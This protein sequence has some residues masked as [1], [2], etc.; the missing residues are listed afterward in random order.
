MKTK[1]KIP[2]PDFDTVKT[3]REIKEQISKE[4]TGM[5]FD[6]IKAYLKSGS[7]KFQ[8]QDI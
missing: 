4:M 3:F 6:E 2:E 1:T 8:K 7:L 5:T